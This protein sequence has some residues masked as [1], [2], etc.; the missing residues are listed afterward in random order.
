MIYRA[1]GLSL[2]SDFVLTQLEEV[3]DVSEPVVRIQR[4]DLSAIVADLLPGQHYVMAHDSIF[5]A[6][7]NVG[8]F[9]IQ[10]GQTVLVDPCAGVQEGHL[11][12]YIMGS[13]MGAILHQRGIMPLHGSCVCRDGKAILITGDSGAGK[14]T[15]AAEFLSRGWKLLTDDVAVIQDIDSVPKVQSSYPSQKLWQDAIDHYGHEAQDLHPLYRK[16][17][18]EKFGI[19]AKAA[20]VDDTVPL[21]LVVRL[22][23]SEHD[24]G[25]SFFDGF[26]KV[27]QLLQNTYR[28]HMIEDHNRQAHFQKCVTLAGKIPMALAIRAR[29][30]HCA[31]ELYDKLTALLQE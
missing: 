24:C 9:Q 26:A 18:Q 8:A 2:I 13:C 5:F 28:A 16:E 6:V 1:F 14:S 21:S 17:Q 11:S 15:L 25:A 19:N 31:A 30:R 10:N 7:D 20:Y 29:D 22:M 23:A 3:S 12:V 27:N 4:A